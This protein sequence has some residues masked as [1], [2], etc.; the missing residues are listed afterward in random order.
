MS[1][2]L[3]EKNEIETPRETAKKTSRAEMPSH[4][5]II[6]KLMMYYSRSR[7]RGHP[8]LWYFHAVG[9]LAFRLSFIFVIMMVMRQQLMTGDLLL[10]IVAGLIPLYL[11]MRPAAYLAST[12]SNSR[13][14]IRHPYVC[15][16]HLVCARFLL[17]TATT[18]FAGVVIFGILIAVGIAPLPRDPL[19]VVGPCAVLL[20]VGLGTGTLAAFTYPLSSIVGMTFRI[21]L[22][23]LRMTA[24]VSFLGRALPP[25][26]MQLALWNPV[27]HGVELFREAYFDIQKNPHVS[28]WY[29]MAWGAGLL[30]LGLAIERVVHTDLDEDTS[31]DAEQTLDSSII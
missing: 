19:G 14:V 11:F 13:V 31:E 8:Q 1:L 22:R 4:W 5:T 29:P 23:I 28:Y 15:H 17:E 24:A 27:F 9:R 12:M 20:F 10:V 26:L 6:Y 2:A 7:F 18:T 3:R 16:L 21:L 30:L 25:T